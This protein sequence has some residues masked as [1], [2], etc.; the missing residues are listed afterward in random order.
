MK[1]GW[2]RKLTLALSLWAI[3]KLVAYWF[4]PGFVLNM[5]TI[6]YARWFRMP[7][8]GSLVFLSNYDGSW[9]STSRISSPRR[10]RASRR[11][12]VTARAYRA[13]AT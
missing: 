12:G 13:P 5:G 8:S 4:R 9:E 1:E 6:H 10:I 2:L 3:G 11:C 7:D